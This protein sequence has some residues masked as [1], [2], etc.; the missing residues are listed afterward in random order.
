MDIQ[1]AAG[2]LI[3]FLGENPDL[4]SQF[5]QHPYSTT[6]QATGSDD[7]ISQEDMSQI[8]TQ[9]AAQSTDQ[10]LGSTDTANIASMLMGANGGSVH[11]LTSALF[12]GAPASAASASS[13]AP[14][15]G[16]LGG[17]VDLGGIVSSLLGGGSSSGA[18]PST[19]DILA[20]SVLG[21]VTSRGLASLVTSAMGTNEAAKKAASTTAASSTKKADSS[22]A[23]AAQPDFSTLADLAKMF[24]K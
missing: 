2:Q 4:I 15:A 13:S 24:L 5:V 21:G 6:A 10:R 14:K 20:K 12:G 1:A 9:V 11:A 8:V 3:S 23:P 19:G 16:G 17:M 22:N 18:A 7:T